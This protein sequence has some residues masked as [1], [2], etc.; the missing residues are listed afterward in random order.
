MGLPTCDCLQHTLLQDPSFEAGQGIWYMTIQGPNHSATQ[1]LI[2]SIIPPTSTTD[3][4]CWNY[5]PTSLLPFPAQQLGAP[6]NCF[7]IIVLRSDA[8]QSSS[9][10]GLDFFFQFSLYLHLV[11]L[12]VAHLL[13]L[14]EN[15]YSLYCINEGA[16]LY[17]PRGTKHLSGARN[18]I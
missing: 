2:L 14:G 13:S 18:R 9:V 4:L 3:L 10:A 16:A 17:H 1:Q 15:S 5:Q 7:A 8:S 6:G 11:I 12:S